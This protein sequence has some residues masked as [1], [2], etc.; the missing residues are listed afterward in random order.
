[1][2]QRSSVTPRP[3]L[4]EPKPELIASSNL[5][6][7]VI[8]INNAHGLE[9][10][11]GDY[12]SLHKWTIAHPEKFWSSVATFTQFLPR[13]KK[14]DLRTVLVRGRDAKLP[15]L[16]NVSWFRGIQLNF[17]Q[18]VLR[19]ARTNSRR[20]AISY[21]PESRGDDVGHQRHISFGALESRV[22]ALASALRN[23]GVGCGDAVAGILANTPD[24]VI[25]MLATAAL[26][27]VWSCC[28]PDFGETA[29]LER[30]SQTNPKVMFY[31]SAHQYKEKVYSVVGKVQNVVAQLP[32]LGLVLSVPAGCPTSNAVSPLLMEKIGKAQH[33]LLRDFENR[34]SVVEDFDYEMMTMDDAVVTMFSSGTTGRPKCIVQGSGILLNQLKEHSLHHEVTETSVMLFSTSTSWMLFNWLLAAVATGCT[35]VLYD[36]AAVPENDPY[37]LVNIANQAGATHFGSGAKY[38]K[39][40]KFISETKDDSPKK[41]GTSAIPIPTLRIVMGTG[42]PSTKEHFRF[43]QSFFGEHIQYVSMSGGTEIN[44]CF[45]LGTP[46]KPVVLSE[47]QCA[48]LGMDVHVFDESGQSITDRNGELVCL[49]ACPCMP[50]YFGHDIEHSRYKSSYFDVFGQD[51]WNHGDFAVKTSQGGF[52]ISGR[53]DSVLNPGGVRIGTSDIYQIV[54]ALGFVET[55]LVT[56]QIVGGDSRVIMFIVTK[57][58]VTLDYAKEKMV[59]DSLRNGLS[60]RHVPHS[61]VQ[62]PDVPCTFS[63][64]K[65]EIPVKKILQGKEADNKEAVKNPHAFDTIRIALERKGLLY[66]RV[67]AANSPRCKM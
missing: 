35:I 7:F 1:M 44:G 11:I 6:K 34:E 55:S 53:S 57:K 37:R 27:G 14:I 21:W 46:W 8:Y 49:N 63:G 19:Y 5:T 30:F 43:A 42:S 9:I 58:N 26:G 39:V 31:S 36:G 40:L 38:F 18:I 17:A 51:V 65:C 10:P 29:I 48:G 41:M 67:G 22:C 54:E 56:E 16:V 62:I 50:L 4:W 3:V 61:I 28:S 52:L 15:T 47:L 33:F 64:K 32:S 45:A 66:P 13:D 23:A 24:A 60:P 25:A 20:T 59:R 2:A 12:A